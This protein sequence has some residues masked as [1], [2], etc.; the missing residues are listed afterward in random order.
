MLLS[1]KDI[2]IELINETDEFEKLPFS[3]EEDENVY[4]MLIK[5]FKAWREILIDKYEMPEELL[6][7][8]QPNS[9]L[10]NLRLSCS[11]KELMYFINSCAKYNELIDIVEKYNGVLIPAHAFTPHKSFYGNCT[12]SLKK[13]FKEKFD[14]VF[15]IELGLS[16]DTYLADEIS[17]LKDVCGEVP[18]KVILETGALQSAQNIK[19]AAVLAMYSGAD[20]IKTSTGKIAVNATPE[21]TYVM[22]TAI[23]DWHTKTGKKVCYK[24]AGGV[25]TTDEAVQHYTLVKDILGKDWLNNESFRF[26]ASRL[27]NNLLTSILGK[28]VKYF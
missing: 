6:A 10:V 20:F 8:I 26:G 13:I 27:A 17:E 5:Q 4:N 28:E 25:S 24:P 21:A 3:S 19:K 22:C 2:N 23:K 14:K 9:R 18:L 16:S 7:Y 12:S 15:A 1:M 11:I